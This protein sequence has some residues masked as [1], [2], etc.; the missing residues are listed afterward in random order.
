MPTRIDIGRNG[1]EKVVIE[2]NDS[3]VEIYRLGA[4]IT[5]YA[6]GGKEIIFLSKTS[7][8]SVGKAIRGGVPICWPWFGPHPT[9]PKL[10]QHGLVR[11][12]EWTVVSMDEDVTVL[13]TL[14]DA[15]T[16]KHFPYPFKLQLKV[17]LGKNGL[18]FALTTSNTGESAFTIGEALHTYFTVSDITQTTTTGFQDL[19]YVDKVD[20]QKLK[21]ETQA[22]VPITG[23]TDR[24]YQGATGPH[25]IQHPGGRVLVTKAGSADTVYWNPWEKKAEG[26]AD[27]AGNQWPGFVCVEAVNTGA[28]SV[29]VQP[30]QSHTIACNIRAF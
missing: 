12:K 26:L 1:L 28:N 8:F 15:E 22:A 11:A 17:E 16:L 29:T 3:V 9:D 21:Q 4:C 23:E 13:E 5:R 18:T 7:H 10:P 20:G 30:G 25:Q 27:L 2:T 14:S 24:V 19:N 6:T